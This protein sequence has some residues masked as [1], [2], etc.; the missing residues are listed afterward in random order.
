MQV[1]LLLRM[2][3]HA[4]CVDRSRIGPVR[5]VLTESETRMQAVSL[6]QHYN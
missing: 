2:H 5:E 4:S 6:V 1:S 3:E